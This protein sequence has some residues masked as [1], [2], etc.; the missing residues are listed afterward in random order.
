MMLNEKFLMSN[1]HFK[2]FVRQFCIPAFSFAFEFDSLD[3]I[4]IYQQIF[5]KHFK[6]TEK[7]RNRRERH[8][9]FAE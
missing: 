7:W 8:L 2:I 4:W 1:R 9:P 6:I 5:I 3:L